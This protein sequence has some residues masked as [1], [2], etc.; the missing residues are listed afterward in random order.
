MNLLRQELVGTCVYLDILQKTISA[1]EDTKRE[2]SSEVSDFQDLNAEPKL[3]RVAEEK[4]V[5]FCGHLLKDA[6]D[7]QSSVKGTSNMEIHRVLELRSP[8]IV[9]VINGMSSMN[10]HIFR[11]HLGEFYPLLTKLLC[12]DQMAIRGALGDLFR[13]QLSSLLP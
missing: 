3:D 13:S 8:I 6:S 5:S 7:F 11:K 4:L 9:K 1:F 2:N 12:C 10:S